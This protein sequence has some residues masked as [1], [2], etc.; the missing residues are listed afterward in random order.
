MPEAIHPLIPRAEP[1]LFPGTTRPEVGCLLIHGF[2]G[3]PL[4]MRGLGEHLAQAGL[5]VL[6]VRLAGHATRLEDMIHSRWTDW[7][8]SVRDGYEMLHSACQQVFVIGLSM[9]GILALTLASHFSVAGVAAFS[10][11]H[12]L[13]P[14]PRLPIAKW[15]ALYKPTI[16]KGPPEWFDMEAY[17]RHVSYPADPVRSYV[18]LDKMLEVMRA[19]LPRITAPVLL[20]YSRHDPTIRAA[21][22]HMETILEALGS[23]QKQGLWIEN[24]GHVITSDAQRET[25]YRAATEFIIQHA[26]EPA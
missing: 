17:A 4:E 11:P 26:G 8:A 18:E 23:D 22:G 24:S 10:T 20:I 16:P 5:T 6:G 3:T 25:V 21:D 9:G 15:I 13:P 12:H 2:T 7:F 1:F 14:D 19:G